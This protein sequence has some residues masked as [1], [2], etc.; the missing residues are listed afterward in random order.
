MVCVYFTVPKWLQLIIFNYIQKQTTNTCTIQ[1]VWLD[2]IFKAS[3]DKYKLDTCIIFSK[4]KTVPV[5]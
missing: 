1:T 3:Q 4:R 5:H 2:Q